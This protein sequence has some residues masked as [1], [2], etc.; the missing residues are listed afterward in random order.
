MRQKHSR[1]DKEFEKKADTLPD[2]LA[3]KMIAN[4]SQTRRELE[5]QKAK[6]EEEKTEN[7]KA[8]L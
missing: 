7:E 5:M 1:S 3:D 4:Y 2:W 8:M 6:T